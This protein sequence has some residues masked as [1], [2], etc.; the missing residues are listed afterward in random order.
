[1]ISKVTVIIPSYNHGRYIT[2]ALN[3]VINQSFSNLEILIIDDGSTDNTSEIIKNIIKNDSRIK[4]IYQSNS[5]LSSARNLG[6][7]HA[8]GQWIQFLDADD[9]IHP[10]KIRAQID[11][12]NSSKYSSS[13]YFLS[14][15]D[16][17]R[18][19]IDNI[20]E[21]LF[22]FRSRLPI[23]NHNF[24]VDV[25][26]NWENIVS[27]PIHAF[28]FDGRLF[29]DLKLR[30]D[31]SLKNHEDLDLLLTLA[32]HNVQIEYL[33]GKY[34]NYTFSSHSMSGNAA[35]MALGFKIVVEKHLRM[36]NRYDLFRYLEFKYAMLSDGDLLSKLRFKTKRIFD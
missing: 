2:R 12:Y 11:K 10:D 5:G 8:S 9:V 21:I 27:I 23:N 6:L 35:D 20:E 22:D 29:N 30:F 32:N 19:K 14:F 16:Y 34:A 13:K 18:S 25:I 31:T 7:D 33:D 1:M 26:L 17:F 24:F 36:I 4:Y 3:S 15:T 28:L